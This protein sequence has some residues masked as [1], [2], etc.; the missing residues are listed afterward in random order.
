MVLLRI[1]DDEWEI[2][3]RKKWVI[4]P[5][6]LSVTNDEWTEYKRQRITSGAKIETIKRYERDRKRLFKLLKLIREQKAKAKPK[7]KEVKERPKRFHKT[8]IFVFRCRVPY[9]SD[10]STIKEHYVGYR[11]VKDEP[12]DEQIAY[13]L[14]K[15]NFP[16]H[17]VLDYWYHGSIKVAEK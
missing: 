12:A 15:H 10:F 17:V 14:H 9:W 3:N 4:S 6:K 8:H 1:T 7:L 5:K 16:E 11:V 13:R 2:I